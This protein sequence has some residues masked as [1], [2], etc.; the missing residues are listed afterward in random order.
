MAETRFRKRLLQI[1][2]RYVKGR[3]SLAEAGF[4]E[5]YYDH[6]DERGSNDPDGP[7]SGSIEML[8]TVEEQKTT[9]ERVWSKIGLRV[10]ELELER[11]KVRGLAA[12]P[13]LRWSVAA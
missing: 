5:S 2:R 11:K 8:M 4:M 12:Y 7:A 13:W 10:V 9:E 1:M 3:A 6:F